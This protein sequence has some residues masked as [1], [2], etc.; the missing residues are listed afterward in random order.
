M[1]ETDPAASAAAGTSELEGGAPSPPRPGPS[2]PGTGDRPTSSRRFLAALFAGLLLAA[3]F[4]PYRLPLLMPFGI[5]A[6]LWSLAG[7]TVRQAFYC[8][9][10]CGIIYFGATLFWLFNL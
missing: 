2:Q 10:L 6:L 9:L 3:S 8:G 1:T 5:G 4:P 7:S